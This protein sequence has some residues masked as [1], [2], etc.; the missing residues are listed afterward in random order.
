M[1]DHEFS[2]CAGCEAKGDRARNR[3]CVEEIDEGSY[4]QEK[5]NLARNLNSREPSYLE[6]HEV[7]SALKHQLETCPGE[8]R[9]EGAGRGTNFEAIFQKWTSINRLETNL[10]SDEPS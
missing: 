5:K 7:S 6:N 3:S 9:E 2:D 10:N 8:S 1:N 4:Q